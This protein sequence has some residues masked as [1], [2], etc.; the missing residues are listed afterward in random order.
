MVFIYELEH[1]ITK[2]Q[3]ANQLIRLRKY[4]ILNYEEFPETYTICKVSPS[5]F[6]TNSGDGGILTN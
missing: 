6:V 1:C 2:T 4:T 3:E 5:D